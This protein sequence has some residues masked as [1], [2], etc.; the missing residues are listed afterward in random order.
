MYKIER[1]DFGYKLTFGDI[2]TVEEMTTWVEESKQELANAPSEF[3]VF[4][5]MR[6][7]KPL[8]ADTVKVME[9]GQA[10]YKEKGMT[11][12]V[13]ILNSAVVTMQFI[14]IAKDS[15]IYQWE[16]YIDASSVSDWEKVG[17]AWIVDEKDPDK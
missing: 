13:V 3:G 9:S 10:F 5:D 15:G 11:R 6:T 17:L 7:L 8:A 16:R 1:K 12:S 2:I 14:R 4:V